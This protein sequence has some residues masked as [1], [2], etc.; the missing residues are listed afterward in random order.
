MA[1][2][3]LD[4]HEQSELVRNWLRSNGGFLFAGLVVGIG[5][6]VGNSFY[7]KWRATQ[8]D[9]AG[10]AYAKYLE[11]VEKKD[12]ETI[13]SLG[14]NLRSEHASSP[15]AV[16]SAMS[17]AQTIIAN[18]GELDAALAS[19]QWA[20]EHAKLPELESLASL[21]LARA[22][23]QTGALDKAL[24]TVD[25]IEGKGFAAEIAELRGDIRLAQGQAAAAR[26]AYEEAL[27]GMDATA[28]RRSMVEM[29]RDDLAVAGAV[30]PSAAGD[31]SK[32][33]G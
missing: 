30:T 29:K 15:Y 4:E 33:G 26:A 11:A 14:E 17:E 22:Q 2:E 3:V 9:Q 8:I 16:L 28:P 27:L 6:I 24:V 7:D 25:G 18:G 20:A 13:K 19:L 5:V 32:A 10:S 12:Q 31:A 1:I 23:L 21:R